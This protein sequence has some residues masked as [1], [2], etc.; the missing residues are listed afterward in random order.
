MK[1]VVISGATGKMGSRIRDVV[2]RIDGYEVIAA[3]DSTSDTTVIRQADLLIDSTRLD[4]SQELVSYA[5]AHGVDTLV[6]TSG[7][8]EEKIAELSEQVTNKVDVRVAIIP[9][10]ALGSVLATW[11]ATMAAKYIPQVE[12]IEAHHEGKV[13]APSGTA[14]R[15]AELIAKHRFTDPEIYGEEL[16]SRGQFI[17]GIPVHSLRIPGIVANQKVI[18]GRVGETL[19]IE[20]DTTSPEAYELGIRQAVLALADRESGVVVGLDELLGWGK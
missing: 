8:S 13:D 4:V 17:S 14:V 7:W 6:A 20:H 19:T 3:L 11:L 5:I 16:P 9:N 10:F 1:K 15:A 2:E 18:F 12:I